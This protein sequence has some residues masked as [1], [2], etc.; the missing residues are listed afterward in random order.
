MP[1]SS[2]TAERLTALLRQIVVDKE[3]VLFQED[4]CMRKFLLNRTSKVN[5]L[6]EGM[7]HMLLQKIEEWILS[8]IQNVIVAAGA[9][10]AFCS[11][12]DIEQITIYG[13]HPE[14][15]PNAVNFIYMQYQL[16]SI[17]SAQPKPYVA[18]MDG[19]VMGGG[20]G[21]AA[22]A[23]FRIATERTIFAMPETRIGYFPDI[24]AS[25]FL[26]RADG[27]IGTFLALTAESL[28]ERA[29]FEHGF[30]THFILPENIPHTLQHIAPL[31]NPTC[32]QIDTILR[33]HEAKSPR[34]LTS[35]L[36]GPIRVALDSAFKHS[37]VEDIV[38][39]LTCRA[40]DSTDPV[41]SEWAKRTLS[42]LSLRSPTSLKVA[43]QV[44][45]KGRSLPLLEAMQMEL[46]VATAYCHGAG[47]DIFIGVRATLSGKK[48]RP[49]WGPSAV[50]GVADSKY[51]LEKGN[52][53]RVEVPE[54]LA[55]AV[56]A[57][58]T[59]F[60]LPTENE[61]RQMIQD[62]STGD[63]ISAPTLEEVVAKLI[64]LKNGK[65]GVIDKV[66]EVVSRKCRVEQD[67]PL[68][69]RGL[70]WFD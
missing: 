13:S 11:G 27:E 9:G 55:D 44:L 49:K 62:H 24:G 6:T 61:I 30:A 35:P 39:E 18:V 10:N 14:T 42:A 52:V 68:G 22:N 57:D 51:S 50:E 34:C 37:S 56:P 21:L 40:N 69:R 8:D 12:G 63:D 2:I 7:L 5:A 26:S 70:R 59:R 48:G 64:E 3:L 33:E 47:P 53:P 19:V 25:Y 15:V 43:L 4:G 36:I 29:V 58:R 65:E 46:N 32:E 20:V 23:N 54:Y 28:R 31:N 38:E 16:D 66:L 1:R 17:L 60:A 67:N 41:V 45:R